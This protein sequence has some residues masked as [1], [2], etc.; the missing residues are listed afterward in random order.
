MRRGPSGEPR[1][2][3]PVERRLLLFFAIVYFA[4]GTAG[5]LSKQPVIYYFKS[6]GMGADA[7]AAVL[8]LT[9]VPWM[10]KPLYGLLTDLVPLCGYRRK[11]YLMLMGGLAACGYLSL[12]EFLSPQMIGWLLLVATLG[13]AAVDVVADALMVE[14]GLRLGCVAQFQSQQWTWLNMAAVTAALTGGWLSHALAPDAAF[15]TAAL[16]MVAAPAAVLIATWCLVHERPITIARDDTRRTVRDLWRVL[17]SRP[18]WT[19]GS[20]LICWSL[21][22]NFS[23]P[24][25]YHVVDR[26]H[27]DQYFIGQLTCIGSL[28]AAAGAYAYRRW[29]VDCLSTASLL[30]LSIVSS[31][32]MAVAYLGLRD[33]RSAVLLYFL[34][35][36]V[37][38]TALLTLFGLAARVC[39][40]RAAGFTFAALMSLYSAAAQVSA[41]LTGYLYERVFVHHMTPLI[42]LAALCTLGILA[43]VPLF[44]SESD[45]RMERAGVP[46]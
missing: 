14:E 46:G 18:F 44:R 41:M 10:I 24:L 11:S 20:L 45:G 6:L 25:Y 1:R 35:G 36:A 30:A 28:G 26:L 32:G 19:V 4:Q 29:L 43:W 12:A 7:V 8:A 3:W 17:R 5:G 38:V 31:A 42:Y 34:A 40:P 13:I 2:A 9:A 23:T 37:S 22:P 21:I 39:P 16:L 15:R 27:F 33:G